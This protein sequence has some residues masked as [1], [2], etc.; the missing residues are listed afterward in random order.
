MR[1]RCIRVVSGSC[2]RRLPVA[3]L[4][5][6]SESLVHLAF[7]SAKTGPFAPSHIRVA[8][9]GQHPGPVQPAAADADDPRQH[10]ERLQHQQGPEKGRSSESSESFIRVVHVFPRPVWAGSGSLIRVDVF[11]ACVC[12]RVCAR[13]RVRRRGDDVVPSV[14]MSVS[15]VR[16]RARA[17]V[18][19]R[20]RPCTASSSCAS[21]PTVSGHVP[22][23]APAPLPHRMPTTPLRT[24]PCLGSRVSS[25]A[26]RSLAFVAR[27]PSESFVPPRSVAVTRLRA[28]PGDRP[29]ESLIR[30]A[31]SSRSS[32][33][34]IRVADPG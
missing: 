13:A 28:S 18:R 33:S 5:S 32:E 6:L 9:A 4:R 2:F 11:P 29:S 19:W 1:S 3:H 20:R 22:P 7:S 8:A 21:R 30:V 14:P 26:R 23:S 24:P 16:A 34:L 27:A 17:A 10:A 12:A 15:C 31:H 25:R